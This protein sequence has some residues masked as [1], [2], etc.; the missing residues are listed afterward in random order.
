[1][2]QF[3]ILHTSYSKVQDLGSRYDLSSSNIMISE[4][5]NYSQHIRHFNT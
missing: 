1:M 5:Y 3:V 4:K 2:S